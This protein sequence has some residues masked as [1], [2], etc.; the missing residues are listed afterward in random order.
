MGN[1]SPRDKFHLIIDGRNIVVQSMWTMF[2]S[3]HNMK[4][5]KGVGIS[6]EML[7]FILCIE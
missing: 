4:Q 1:T 7:T 6:D 3:N 5:F 2:I